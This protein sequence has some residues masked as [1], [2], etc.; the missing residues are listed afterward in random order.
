MLFRHLRGYCLRAPSDDEGG[1]GG[2]GASVFNDA[3]LAGIKAIVAGVV[4][5][6]IAARDKMSDK[7]RGEDAKAAETRFATLLDEKLAAF[8]PTETPDDGVGGKS[9]KGG[10]ESVELATLRRSIQETKDAL[11]A[12]N[13]KASEAQAKMRSSAL[14]QTTAEQLAALGIDG[15]RFKGAFAV[16]QQEGRIRMRDDESDEM[17]FVDDTGAEVEL[18]AGLAGWAKSD[19]AKIYLPP[20][21]VRGSGSTKPGPGGLPAGAKP[22][23]DQQWSMI[24]SAIKERLGEL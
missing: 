8:K 17:V 3:Q 5:Q 21:G 23:N 6:T 10:K 22:T 4:N 1:G 16:L 15:A 20:S 13:R 14:R 24:G 7:K 2:G 12:S 11:E 19:D 9:G 18:A